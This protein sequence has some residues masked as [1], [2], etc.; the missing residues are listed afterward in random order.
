MT[1][2]DKELRRIERSMIGWRRFYLSRFRAWVCFSVLR[3]PRSYVI[4]E[5]GRRDGGAA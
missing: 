4:V 2:Y 5:T 3:R 1:T